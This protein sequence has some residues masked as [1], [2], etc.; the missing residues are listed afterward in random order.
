M[1][2]DFDNAN[3]DQKKNEVFTDL[4]FIKRETIIVT[5]DEKIINK[6]NERLRLKRTYEQ[7]PEHCIQFFFLS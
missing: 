4:F 7:L 3:N 1:T 2:S 6:A 5:P